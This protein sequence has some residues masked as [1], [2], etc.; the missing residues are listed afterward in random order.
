VVA[1]LRAQNVQV[2]S[3][4][5]N[6]PPMPD[7]GA[8]QMNVETLGRL[9]VPAQFGNIIVKTDADGR[10]TRI[11]DIGRVE[12]GAQDYGANGYLDEQTAVPLLIFQ[13]PG[14]NALATAKLLQKTMAELAK[15]FPP[16]LA[17]SIVYNP[18]EFIAESVNEVVK[19]MFEA[20]GL[21]VIVVILFLQT[22]RASIV[23]IVAIPVSLVGT[24]AVLA[25]LGFSLNNLSLFG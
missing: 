13:R 5:I 1:A 2:A 19:T 7:Q 11:R 16:G 22:W 12:L 17:Y 24:F 18:T 25:A 23:P 6:Q 4:V 14:S 3:G 10:V 15:S 21:V 9:S 20:V 8:F